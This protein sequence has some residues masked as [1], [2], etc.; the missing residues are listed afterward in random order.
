MKHIKKFNLNTNNAILFVKIQ[1]CRYIIYALK[2]QDYQKLD[3]MSKVD[4]LKNLIQSQTKDWLIN[5]KRGN[6]Q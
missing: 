4:Y 5:S 1:I 6:L 3:H 2:M